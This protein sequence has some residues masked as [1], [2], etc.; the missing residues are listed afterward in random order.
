MGTTNE[1][2]C[3]QLT[4]A[5]VDDAEVARAGVALGLD[6]IR[7]ARV[8]EKLAAEEAR[9]AERIAREEAEIRAKEEAIKAEADRL[10][11][12]KA[13]R[14]ARYAARKAKK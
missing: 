11:Q 1:Q 3:E 2:P 4:V 7:A 5:S 8:A 14:D 9:N 10:A 6:R 12:Q 13:L